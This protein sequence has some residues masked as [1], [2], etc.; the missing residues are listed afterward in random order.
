MALRNEKSRYVK[1]RAGTWCLDWWYLESTLFSLQEE[2]ILK[3]DLSIPYKCFSTFD[4][5]SLFVGDW[6][7]RHQKVGTV[8]KQRLVVMGSIF[9]SQTASI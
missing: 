3:L 7:E 4:S 2:H 9:E 1:V 6:K 8:L 5:I